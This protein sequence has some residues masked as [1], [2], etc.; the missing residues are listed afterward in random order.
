MDRA[1]SMSPKQ[2][3]INNIGYF[4]RLRYKCPERVFPPR[5][6]LQWYGREGVEEPSD[7]VPSDYSDLPMFPSC[8]KISLSEGLQ[9]EHGAL[10]VQFKLLVLLS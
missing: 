9:I 3:F 10:V 5:Q 8:P 6:V 7:A 4:A 2:L 1:I